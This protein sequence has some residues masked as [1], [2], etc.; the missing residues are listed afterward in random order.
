MLQRLW[1]YWIVTTLRRMWC[2]RYARYE[3]M[4]VSDFLHCNNF[5]SEL[6]ERM[7]DQLFLFWKILSSGLSTLFVAD[8][9]TSLTLKDDSRDWFWLT[10]TCESRQEIRGPLTRVVKDIIPAIRDDLPSGDRI[11]LTSNELTS[12]AMVDRLF[13]V[14]DNS[15]DRNLMESFR[16]ALAETSLRDQLKDVDF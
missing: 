9:D 8:I 12:F 6:T 16:S 15:G 1:G 2:L 5:S 14:L 10:F 3:Y 13:A 7:L 11:A 4:L